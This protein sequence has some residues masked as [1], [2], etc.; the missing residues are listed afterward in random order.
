VGAEEE[1]EEEKGTLH[2]ETE[3]DGTKE[4]NSKDKDKEDYWQNIVAK[5]QEE[6]TKV[7]PWEEP[8]LEPPILDFSLETPVEEESKVSTRFCYVVFNS[9]MFNATEVQL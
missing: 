7:G 5:I 2:Q 1:E 4:D 6:G 3:Q 8:T 9:H